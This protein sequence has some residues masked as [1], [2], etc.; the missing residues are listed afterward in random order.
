MAFVIHPGKS[1]GYAM[2]GTGRFLKSEGGRSIPPGAGK[3]TNPTDTTT[4]IVTTCV[5]VALL[6]LI[7]GG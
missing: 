4:V 1:P 2:A 5:F 6:L 7:F 3:I